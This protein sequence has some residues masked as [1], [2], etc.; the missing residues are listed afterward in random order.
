ME[1]CSINIPNIYHQQSESD[2]E[3]KEYDWYRTDSKRFFFQTI[4]IRDIVK[5]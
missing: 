3:C 1:G 5:R 4:K 2:G